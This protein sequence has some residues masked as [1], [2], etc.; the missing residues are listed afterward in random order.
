MSGLDIVPTVCEL[1]GIET[2]DAMR[3]RSLVPLL[4]GSAT[5]WRTSLQIQSEVEGRAIRTH[6]YKY[7]AYRDDSAE[8][9][10][11]LRADPWELDNLAE[12]SAYT[13]VLEEHRAL[14][15]EHEAVLEPTALSLEGYDSAYAEATG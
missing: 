12:D 8:Q 11:D 2:P 15:E 5:E 14:Q 13:T 1:V 10:F 7:I 6:T 4:D 9:L 3:G